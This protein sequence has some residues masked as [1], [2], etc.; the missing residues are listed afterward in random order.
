M[1]TNPARC[2]FER[3]ISYVE[4]L[5]ESEVTS[6]RAGETTNVHPTLE[7]SMTTERFVRRPIQHGHLQGHAKAC[8]RAQ[9]EPPRGRDVCLACTGH[10]QAGLAPLV[11]GNPL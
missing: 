10:G 4:T 1:H 2:V 11:Q 9:W 8:H 5:L 7:A 6:M 3:G